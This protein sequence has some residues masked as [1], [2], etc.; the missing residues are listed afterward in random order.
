MVAIRT[1]TIEPRGS[2]YVQV[3]EVVDIEWR[4]RHGPDLEMV[5]MNV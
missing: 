4:A 1:T 5:P 2:E 3:S